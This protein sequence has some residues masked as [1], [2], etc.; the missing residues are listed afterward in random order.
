MRDVCAVT[1]FFFQTLT[2]GDKANRM[3]KNQKFREIPERKKNKKNN[4]YIYNIIKSKLYI[5]IEPL[6]KH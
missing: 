2:V 4:I 3:R 5:F 6:G 1:M